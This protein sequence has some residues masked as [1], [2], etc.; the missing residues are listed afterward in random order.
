MPALA[1]A[2]F[3]HLSANGCSIQILITF[4]S[5]R[6]AEVWVF[7]REG[8]ASLPL[9]LDGSESGAKETAAKAIAGLCERKEPCK[10]GESTARCSDSRRAALV[11]V[12]QQGLVREAQLQ[13]SLPD[14]HA[15]L[16]LRCVYGCVRAAQQLPNKNTA[17]NDP[18]RYSWR[19]GA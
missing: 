10:V 13:D 15:I 8:S 12:T 16:A 11:H 4:I 18:F 2:A 7:T 9:Q 17:E 5:N 19:S 1:S 14:L 3:S 6:N